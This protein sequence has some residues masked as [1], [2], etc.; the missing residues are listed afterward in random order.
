MGVGS[1]SLAVVVATMRKVGEKK[2]E[3]FMEDGD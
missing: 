1:L 2:E 3:G